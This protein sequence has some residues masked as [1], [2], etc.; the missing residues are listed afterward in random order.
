MNS[1]E[2]SIDLNLGTLKPL[3]DKI[4]ADPPALDG[5]EPYTVLKDNV[6]EMRSSHSC[7]QMMHSQLKNSRSEL[8]MLEQ[9]HHYL[10]LKLQTQLQQLE[11]VPELLAKALQSSALDAENRELKA[12][13]QHLRNL[14]RD[15]IKEAEGAGVRPLLKRLFR[16]G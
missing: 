4:F 3:L 11:H 16:V 7:N 14:A 1:S 15:L 5:H 13:N 2:E 8:T 6:R 10:E 12:E 9:R